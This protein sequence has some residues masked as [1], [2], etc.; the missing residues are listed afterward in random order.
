MIC[1]KITYKGHVIL[2][3]YH[4]NIDDN[5]INRYLTRT[6][7]IGK[8]NL[9]FT[10][11]FVQDIINED[12][13]NHTIKEEGLLESNSPQNPYGCETCAYMI[14]YIFANKP[15][16]IFRDEEKLYS[17]KISVD[18]FLTICKFIKKYTGIDIKENPM[19]LGD[20]FI[21]KCYER[22][23]KCVQ[24]NSIVLE[25]LPDNSTVIMHFKIGGL[26]VSSKIIKIESA[27]KELVI[28]SDK[29]W[30]SHDIEIVIGDKT[31]Y[32]QN[33]ISY[34]RCVSLNVSTRSIDNSIKLEKIGTMHT[35]TKEHLVETSHIGEP[36]N[37][38]REK[39]NKSS[40]KIK[41][42]IEREYPDDQVFFVKPNEFSIAKDLIVPTIE[43]AK[44]ELWIFDS[45][46]TE[47]D[48]IGKTIDWLRIISICHV[49]SSNFVFYY[50][51][52]KSS[53]LTMDDFLYKIKNDNEIKNILAS[54]KRLG[55]HFYQVASPIHDRF[56]LVKNKDEFHGLSIGTSFNSLER[57]HYCIHKLSHAASK[58]IF[59][60]LVE[61]IDNGNTVLKKEI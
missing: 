40:Q 56:V 57:N 16:S 11:T 42:L 53:N 59:I 52:N 4:Q 17:L 29:S 32:L 14:H 41:N 27:T 60:E 2:T 61:W 13:L 28:S 45:Y 47:N 1:D 18:E 49:D 43:S 51:H 24:N 30:D 31:V 5:V 23:Y 54:K 39:Q 9:T 58:K 48:A 37:E 10:E 50:N 35:T 7:K 3:I 6:E 34:I 19:V 12:F 8:Y 15:K 22:N 20:I 46:L 44:D 38:F 26:I 25:N 36:I 21:F 55:M 33:N